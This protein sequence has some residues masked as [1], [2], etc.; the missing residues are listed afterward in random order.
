MTAEK[1]Q[2][3]GGIGPKVAESVYNWFRDKNKIF[4]EK[5]LKRIEILLPKPIQIIGKQQ[6]Q[7]KS[8]CLDGDDGK[9]I[10]R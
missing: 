7:R 4:L 6:N 2:E 8:F 10:Q 3:S 9:H 5:L 1:L